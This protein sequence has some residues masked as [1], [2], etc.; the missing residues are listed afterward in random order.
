[1]QATREWIARIEM[2]GYQS[3]APVF[4]VGIEKTATQAVFSKSERKMWR[5]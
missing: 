2:V 5:L 4:V 1:M 3:A